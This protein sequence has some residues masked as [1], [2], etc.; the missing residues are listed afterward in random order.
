VNLIP[1]KFVN[2]SLVLVTV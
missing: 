1:E 2:T